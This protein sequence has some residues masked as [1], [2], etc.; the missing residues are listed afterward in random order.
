MSLFSESILSMDIP[1]TGPT[2]L[3][4]NFTDDTEDSSTTTNAN[5]D[6]EQENVGD[7]FAM[8]TSPEELAQATLI[9]AE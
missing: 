3:R 1:S 4:S 9:S 6:L 8:L 5:L 7:R 2:S